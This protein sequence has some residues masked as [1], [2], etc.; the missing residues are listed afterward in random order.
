MV[1]WDPRRLVDE[2]GWIPGSELLEVVSRSTVRTW[3][4]T[5]RLVRLARHLPL[6]FGLM[7]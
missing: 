6:L 7:V 4:A 3:V 5:G 2:P 1:A